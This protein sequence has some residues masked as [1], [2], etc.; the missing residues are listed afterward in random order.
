CVLITYLI[1]LFGLSSLALAITAAER[2]SCCGV[3]INTKW[4]ANSASTLW[5][6]C[7]VRYHSPLPTSSTVIMAGAAGGG[8][9]ADLTS[10]GAERSPVLPLTAFAET[11]I[12][13][14]V[15]LSFFV[16]SRF[17]SFKPAVSA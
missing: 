4:S 1:G 5:W 16:V 9:A 15:Y 14:T 6:L 10:A 11:S 12:S 8:A 2:T 13:A 3:S 17:G 7:P